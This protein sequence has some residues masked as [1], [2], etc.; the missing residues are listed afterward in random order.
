MKWTYRDVTMLESFVLR[1][2]QSPGY[3]LYCNLSEL[4]PRATARCPVGDPGD[5]E[6]EDLIDDENGD[7]PRAV[8]RAVLDTR[9]KPQN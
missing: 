4:N 3:I 6:T 5:G 8:S 2:V 1:D 7:P 9:T